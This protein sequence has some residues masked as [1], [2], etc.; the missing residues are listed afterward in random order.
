MGGYYGGKA[1]AEGASFGEAGFHAYGT[2][3]FWWGAV[4]VEGVGAEGISW[5]G[6]ADGEDYSELW[7]LS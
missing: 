6:D 3:V 7:V 1:E 5:V 4:W 2:I